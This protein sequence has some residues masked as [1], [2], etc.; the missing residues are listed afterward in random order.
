[1]N[2]TDF[3]GVSLSSSSDSWSEFQIPGTATP[4]EQEYV[5]FHVLHPAF[6]DTNPNF[7]NHAPSSSDAPFPAPALPPLLDISLNAGTTAAV[8]THPVASNPPHKKARLTSHGKPKPK[9]SEKMNP[10]EDIPTAADSA[11]MRYQWGNCEE[12]FCARA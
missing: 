7:L 10:E 8:G 9:E 6:S 4:L 11:M 5:Y 1:M 3:Y 12:T 2:F